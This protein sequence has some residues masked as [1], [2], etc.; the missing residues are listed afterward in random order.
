M[1]SILLKNFISVWPD[2]TVTFGNA[3]DLE[4]FR[5]R[6]ERLGR[7]DQPEITEYEGQFAFGLK[8]MLSGVESVRG[9]VDGLNQENLHSTSSSRL[10][11]L[12]GSIGGA[13]QSMRAERSWPF[14]QYFGNAEFADIMLRIGAEDIPAHKV[15]LASNS[16]RFAQ[17]CRNSH[18]GP[19]HPSGKDLL[20]IENIRSDSFYMML[21]WCY[22][23]TVHIAPA[24]DI[25]VDLS[26]MEQEPTQ[27]QPDYFM[28]ERLAELSDNTAHK[29]NAKK[30]LLIAN[31]ARAAQEYGMPAFKEAL[32]E[33]LAQCVAAHQW[34]CF[35]RVQQLNQIFMNSHHTRARHDMDIFV[36]VLEVSYA[37]RLSKSTAFLKQ[38]AVD[39]IEVLQGWSA[40]RLWSDLSDPLRHELR[41]TERRIAADR[42]LKLVPGENG[43]KKSRPV[44]KEALKYHPTARRLYASEIVDRNSNDPG[45]VKK[46]IRKGNHSPDGQESHDGSPAPHVVDGNIVTEDEIMHAKTTGTLALAEVTALYRSPSA[47]ID[48]R[49]VANICADALAV[50]Q[51]T[52]KAMDQMIVQIGSVTELDNLTHELS[53]LQHHLQHYL[54]AALKPIIQREAKDVCST[55]LSQW[56]VTHAH[57]I[58]QAVSEP[59]L[60]RSTLPF[61]IDNANIC[62]DDAFEAEITRL[63][64]PRTHKAIDA[65]FMSQQTTTDAC[66]MSSMFPFT[67]P[68]P[69]MTQ[70]SRV[71]ATLSIAEA[72]KE[73]LA[74]S[75][76]KSLIENTEL[77]LRSLDGDQTAKGLLVGSAPVSPVHSITSTTAREQAGYLHCAQ[78]THPQHPLA[79][80]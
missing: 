73:D 3:T 62:G 24:E 50:L 67:F 36:A 37:I 42:I 59:E 74:A 23:G 53:M 51:P 11:N 10:D 64:F 17:L 58:D 14:A 13:A 2:R 16:T 41:D 19:R 78:L 18:D 40:G 48:V 32:D 45:Q 57:H 55:Y 71:P 29:K 68:T 7:T 44:L 39:E 56:L 61:Q 47:H 38:L 30:L 21:H 63:V 33:E 49:S 60:L 28:A 70:H 5:E 34:K 1:R 31:T 69:S 46:R 79:H 22:T 12:T 6:L 52:V 75:E 76:E 26:W 8:F 80:P 9:N 54:Y 66:S 20:T 35:H 27:Q 4:S 15:V 65:K 77:F 72:L 43:D 25:A